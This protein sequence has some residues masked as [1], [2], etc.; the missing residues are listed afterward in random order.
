M[1]DKKLHT[2][3]LILLGVAVAAAI[4]LALGLFLPWATLVS[5]ESS[6][7]IPIFDSSYTIMSNY[8]GTLSINIV[9]F[10]A[11]LCALGCVVSVFTIIA[12][13][14]ELAQ[15][16]GSSKIFIGIVT[17]IAGVAVIGVTV[18][19]LVLLNNFFSNSAI[20][21]T[22]GFGVIAIPLGAI[23]SGIALLLYK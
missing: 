8:K 22:V 4:V 20:F 11:L 9:R 5:D 12:G 13:V 21:Y 1:S 23:A 14:T 6:S 18:Y 15:V 10:I 17:I 19:Y 2:R 3:Q 7:G 16:G